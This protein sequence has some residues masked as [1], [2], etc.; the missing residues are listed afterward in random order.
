M[1]DFWEPGVSTQRSLAYAIRSSRLASPGF[2]REVQQAVWAVNGNVPLARVATL[3][4]IYRRSMAQTSF[5]LVILGIAAGVALLLGLVG[6]YGVIAYVVSQRQREIGIRIA[7]GASSGDVQALFLRRGLRLT[8]LGLAVGVVAAVALMRMLSALLFGVNA[9]DPVTYAA[10][11][12]TLG[13]VA[14]V[15]TWLPARRA[16]H[17]DP[18][19]ALR[20]E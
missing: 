1:Q 14:L 12:T 19:I 20:A 9:F 11:V 5:A 17:V 2:L 10:V 6:I 13:A 4:D 15:A 18:A 16:G 3:G 7:I 8:A